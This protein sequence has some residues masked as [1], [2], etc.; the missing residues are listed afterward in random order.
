MGLE[1]LSVE[2]VSKMLGITEKTVREFLRAG[3]LKASKLGR[4]WRIH[5][6]DVKAFMENNSN[7]KERN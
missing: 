5:P 7:Q 2:D 6:D 4:I 3:D 1:Y